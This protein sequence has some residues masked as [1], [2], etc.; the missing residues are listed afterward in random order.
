MEERKIYIVTEGEYSDYSIDRVFS[1]REKAE[2]YVDSVGYDTQIEEYDIDAPIERKTQVFCISFGLDKKEAK[3]VY[4]SRNPYENLI[5]FRQ[6]FLDIYV[7]SDSRERAIKI[8]SERYG[9]IIAEEQILFP[10]LR[11]PFVNGN[12]LWK[13][14]I[15]AFFDFNTKEIVLKKGQITNFPLPDF[16]KVR[17]FDEKE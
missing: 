11:V 5:R 15:T 10:Y 4:L 13:C 16:I 7:K 2:E 9:M 12:S 1:T 6:P 8:A 3:Y 14:N 17:Y